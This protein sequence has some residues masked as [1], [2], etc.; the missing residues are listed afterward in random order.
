MARSKYIFLAIVLL[1]G[2][3]V[4]VGRL[5]LQAINAV[6]PSTS[7]RKAADIAYGPDLRHRLDVYA[8]QGMQHP[9]PV[10][11]FF[12]GGGWDS[13]QRDEYAFVGEALASRGMVAVL[14]DY[15]LYPQVRYPGFVEDA[16]LAVA[17]T[18]RE[19]QRYGG[20][21][22]RLFLMGHSAG[23]YNAAMV[24][25]DPRWLATQGMTPAALRGW[26]G[27][28]GPYDFIPVKNPAVRPVFFYPATP[29]DSQPINHVS[30]ATPP[31]L[32]IAP[33][34]DDT[35]D[36]VRNTGG[37]AKQ[38]RAV[39]VNV[40][41]LYYER[42]THRSLIV[43][44]ARP[45]RALAPVLDAVATFIASDGNRLPAEISSAAASSTP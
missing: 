19:V 17:W 35:V 13:G 26:I 42:T 40:T 6:T 10:V 37:L 24:A 41:E 1:I 36:P 22:K 14:A 38:L 39:G 5:P 3:G 44:M 29:P 20:D 45:L 27:L 32:L 11:V 31:A 2:L 15:R 30:A 12:Y 4:V 25:L 21:P 9:V 7:Y 8:P 28:A 23:A 18:A 43:A 33:M 16:A 34:L